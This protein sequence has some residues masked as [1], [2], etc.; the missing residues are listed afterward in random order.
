MQVASTTAS[1][2]ANL[3]RIQDALVTVNGKPHQQLTT[4]ALI[5][6]LGRPDSIAKGAVECGSVLD[7]P[8]N[9]PA[10]DFWYYGKTMY[11]VNGN[12]AILCSFDVTTGKFQGK[13]GQLSLNQNTTLED[14]RQ[15]YPVSAKEADVPA[16]GRAGEVM[17][18]PFEQDGQL[19]D[20]S[21]NLIFKKGGLQE[22]EFFF[23]C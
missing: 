13:V 22:V 8:T 11:D 18:L 7:I 14:I 2:A 23:P 17:S 12:Q 4:Q 16:E 1:D 19:T 3:E 21:L 10:G 15:L 5:K 6:L 20:S 9:S